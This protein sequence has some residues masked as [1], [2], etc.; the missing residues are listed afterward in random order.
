[1]GKNLNMLVLHNSGTFRCHIPLT[2]KDPLHHQGVL[3][4]YAMIV[5]TSVSRRKERHSWN[6]KTD[7]HRVKKTSIQV[8]DEFPTLQNSQSETTASTHELLRK[9]SRKLDTMKISLIA[10]TPIDKTNGCQQPESQLVL[11]PPTGSR[12]VK[13]TARKTTACKRLK[14]RKFFL[15]FS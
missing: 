13:R 1:M 4:Y 11:I 12:T 9:W 6:N 5:Q 3:N 2:F 15:L 8:P 14:F 10:S 7:F